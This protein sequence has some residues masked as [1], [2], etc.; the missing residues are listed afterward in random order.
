M[1]IYIKCNADN[2]S[3]NYMITE[4][5]ADI[6]EDNDNESI[7]NIANN[8]NS[9]CNDEIDD[10]TGI[11]TTKNNIDATSNDNNRDNDIFTVLQVEQ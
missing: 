9:K 8:N 6:D 5:L 1:L 4:L 2:T 10:L 11:D 3:N 7:N